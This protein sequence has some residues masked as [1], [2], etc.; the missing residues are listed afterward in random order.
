MSDAI[1]FNPI[2]TCEY[3][4][5]FEHPR[6]LFRIARSGERDHEQ[7]ARLARHQHP[8]R[9]EAALEQRAASHHPA[10]TGLAGDDNGHALFRDLRQRI[11]ENARHA[12]AAQS[13]RDEPSA[14][15]F[16]ERGDLKR[17]V[18]FLRSGRTGARLGLP[19]GLELACQRDGFL[20][21]RVGVRP[22]VEC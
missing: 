21:R 19:G 3:S 22:G 18:D 8:C 13:R 17:M 16:R 1:C 7:D 20:L 4:V 10:P 12:A 6:D 14:S 11:G 2:F 15:G 5:G 9:N